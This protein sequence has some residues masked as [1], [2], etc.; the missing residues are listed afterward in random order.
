MSD[1]SSTWPDGRSASE[2]PAATPDAPHFQRSVGLFPAIAV[3]MIQICGIGPFITIPA[4]VA[5]MNG[6]LAVIGWVV[7]ALLAMADGLVWAEL[8]AAMPGAGGTYLYVREAF[9]YRTGRLVP[10]LFIWTAMLSIPL[11]MSTGIIGFVQYM[12]FFLPNLLPWQSHAIGLVVTALVVF[13]LYR[14]IE[15]IRSLSA[16]LWIIMVLAVGLTT[17]AAYSDFH[18]NLA[19]SLPPGSGD[20]GKFFTGLGAGLII[21][22]YDYAG[23][24]TTAYMGDELKNPGRVMPRSIIVSIAA[25]MVFYLAMNVGVIGTVPWQDVAKSSSVASLV[26]SRNWGHTAAA[27]VTILILIAAF[28]SVF[29]GLLGG[30]RV[31]FHAARDG[32]FLSAF[33]RLHSKHNFPHVALLVMGVITAAGSFFDLTTVINMLVAVSVLLQS[34]AQIAALTVLRRR[35]PALR[36]PYRQWLYPL[37]SL[38]ALVGWFYVYYATDRQSQILSTAWLV[39]GV[40]AFLI[41]ARVTRV[42]PFG[43]KEVQEVFLERQRQDDA[44]ARVQ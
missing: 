18:L 12:G 19:M 25:M 10:F 44:D 24:N 20:L 21:A 4:I 39:A 30:S 36:R 11:I 15:S 33:G 5:V 29:A 41:W 27:I 6:P 2:A 8:G 3:N 16:V 35:Q 43:P 28:A 1:S 23:Y 9:Q 38:V 37:P 22:I 40:V 31:P 34:V 42:W 26:V 17:A 13:A 32:V 14:R 7:G